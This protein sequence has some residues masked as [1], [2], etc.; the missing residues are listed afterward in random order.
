MKQIYDESKN[1]PDEEAFIAQ[2]AEA[3]SKEID[4]IK[5]SLG[6]PDAEVKDVDVAEGTVTLEDDNQTAKVESE[7]LEDVAEEKLEETVN[8][9]EEIKAFEKKL[10]AY[11]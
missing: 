6:M 7:E 11:L 4:N 5:K 3:L 9:P 10:E 2:V 8:S 1:V